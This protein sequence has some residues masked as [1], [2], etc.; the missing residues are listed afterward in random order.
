MALYWRLG[1]SARDVVAIRCLL[2]VPTEAKK[3]NKFVERTKSALCAE[4][5]VAPEKCTLTT[6]TLQ[7]GAVQRPRKVEFF[8][9]GGALSQNPR[10]DDPRKLRHAVGRHN[11]VQRYKQA[12]SGRKARARSATRPEGSVQWSGDRTT[13]HRGPRVALKTLLSL[14]NWYARSSF[15]SRK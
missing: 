5:H 2:K 4:K 12:N 3:E 15:I 10:P 14:S 11:T 9:T 13:P 1:R 8:P 6:Q 7:S